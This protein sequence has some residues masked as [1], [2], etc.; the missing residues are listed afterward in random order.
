MALGIEA[1]AEEFGAVL[2]VQID[3]HDDLHQMLGKLGT[4][5][6]MPLGLLMPGNRD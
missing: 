6:A 3:S 2:F 5:A 4:L 1:L